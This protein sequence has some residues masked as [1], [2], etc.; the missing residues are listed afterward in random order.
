MDYILT[1]TAAITSSSK[2]SAHSTELLNVT[3]V[4]FVESPEDPQQD[5]ILLAEVAAL[6]NDVK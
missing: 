6:S 4:K 5:D 1:H 2:M 3:A